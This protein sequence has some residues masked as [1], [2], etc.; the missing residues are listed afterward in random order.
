MFLQNPVL[1]AGRY[2]V[3]ILHDKMI[4]QKLFISINHQLFIWSWYVY[5]FV[6]LMFT[7]TVEWER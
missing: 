1:V 2:A 7:Y 4:Y 5:I 3:C 6:K